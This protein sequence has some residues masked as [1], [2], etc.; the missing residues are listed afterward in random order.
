M[1]AV[2]VGVGVGF[3]SADAAGGSAAPDL[4]PDFATYNGAW[5]AD[6]ALRCAVAGYQ[7]PGLYP[8]QLAGQDR[9]L[10]GSQRPPYQ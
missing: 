2:A 4:T 6:Y 1:I 10:Y 8:E 5:P 3:G 7:P 9:V